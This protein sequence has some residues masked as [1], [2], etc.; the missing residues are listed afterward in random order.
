MPGFNFPTLNNIKN[1]DMKNIFKELPYEILW[2]IQRNLNIIK[3]TRETKIIKDRNMEFLTAMVP[4]Y[5]IRPAYNTQ[6][7]IFHPSH[8]KF[9]DDAIEDDSA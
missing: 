5:D 3:K 4:M 2:Q 6:G 1:N 9:F 7:Y 8:L